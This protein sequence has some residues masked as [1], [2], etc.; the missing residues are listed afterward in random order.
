MPTT[1][2]HFS[3][4]HR[5]PQQRNTASTV[6]VVGGRLRSALVCALG[7]LAALSFT[8]DLQAAKFNRGTRPEISDVEINYADGTMVVTGAHFASRGNPWVPFTGA[9]QLSLAEG[10]VVEL[11]VVEFIDLGEAV[12]R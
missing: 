3:Q 6:S 7:M 4:P 5:H 10:G 11:E 12:S 2:H 9:V 1:Q 8:A